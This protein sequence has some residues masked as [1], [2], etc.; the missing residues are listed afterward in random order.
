MLDRHKELQN[1]LKELKNKPLFYGYEVVIRPKPKL[2]ALKRPVRQFRE[3]ASVQNLSNIVEK[4]Q[5]I[6]QE[7]VSQELVHRVVEPLPLRLHRLS[8]IQVPAADF[9]SEIDNLGS[10]VHKR[11]SFNK[12]KVK[13]SQI[14]LDIGTKTIVAAYKNGKN[15][16]YITEINGY[17]PIE[18]ST[19]FIE[20]MLSDPKKKRSDGTERPARFIKLEDGRLII[21][22][23]DAEEFAYSM[24]DTLKRP[25]AEGGVSPDEDALTVLA[26]IVHGI[27]E[28]AEKDLGKFSDEL[29]VC[30]CTTA[31]AINKEMNVDYHKRVIDMILRSYESKSNLKFDSIKESH[32]IVNNMSPD[33]TGIGISWGA[34][35]VTVSYVKYG[36]EIY[37]FCWVGSG[38][39]ID[40]EVARRHGY[41]PERSSLRLKSSKETPTTVARRKMTV[42]LTPGK[43]PTDRIGLDVVM[44]YDVLISNVVDGIVTGFRENEAQARINSGINIYMAGGTASPVGFVERVSAKLSHSELPFEIGG[45]QRHDHTLL[46]V[47]EGLLKAA[48]IF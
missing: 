45:V 11:G 40:N 26:S 24:N 1:R 4:Q 44:H 16:E 15:T 18:K 2:P 13:M 48:E 47:A 5:P 32:A 31:N 6:L 23:R 19:P 34:G 8:D 10:K 35:T 25:M 12:R 33:G 36:M 14:G 27:L 21:L 29:K 17:W 9:I 22:G 38:D 37:S 20:N 28:T 30:Y 3:S 39:W 42:D 43:E 41:D 46:C 7:T